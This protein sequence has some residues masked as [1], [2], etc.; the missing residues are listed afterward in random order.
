[1]EVKDILKSKRQEAELSQNKLAAIMHVDRS[2]IS[3]WETENQYLHRISSVFC[4]IFLVLMK[5][6]L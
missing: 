3:R 6:I 2:M 5:Q 4:V 1:M